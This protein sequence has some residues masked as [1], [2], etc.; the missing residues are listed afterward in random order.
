MPR[1]SSV[2]KPVALLLLL[3]S[4]TAG[5][6]AVRA[7][8]ARVFRIC[9]TYQPRTDELTAA[10]IS[11]RT[12]LLLPDEAR[13]M[14]SLMLRNPRATTVW[15]ELVMSEEDVQEF[16]AIPVRSVKLSFH[17]GFHFS[18]ASRRDAPSWWP[19]SSGPGTSGAVDYDDW[20]E[21]LILRP[22]KG[23]ALLYVY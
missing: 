19:R 11:Q 23:Y 7:P 17:D 2:I 22:D 5:V 21:I 14:R 10:D 20:L 6:L 12:S 8:L 16:M 18:E 1:L 3:G 13:A 9:Q 4:L 15:A